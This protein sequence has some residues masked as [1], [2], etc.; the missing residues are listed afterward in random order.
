MQAS[1]AEIVGNTSITE[2]YTMFGFKDYSSFYRAFKKEYGISPKE[3]K[4][5]H[6]ITA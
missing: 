3:Y 5:L 2:V 4:E 6:G 1:K